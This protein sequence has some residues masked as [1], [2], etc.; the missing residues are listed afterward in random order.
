MVSTAATPTALL[1]VLADPTRLRILALL[2]REELAVGELCRSLDLA[3]SRVSNH[4]RVLREADFLIERHAGSSIYLRNALHRPGPDLTPGTEAGLPGGVDLATSLWATVRRDLGAIPEHAGDLQRLEAVLAERSA[5]GAAFFDRLAGEWDKIGVDFASGQARQRAAASLLPTDQVL[6]DLGCGT[7]YVAASLLGLCDRLICVDNSDAMLDQARTRLDPM[8][9][10]TRVEYR[11]GDM[12]AL[13]L[14]E[15]EVDGLVAGM[16][17]HHLPSLDGAVRE[18]RRVLK[19]GGRA[20]VLDLMPHNEAWM[21]AALGDRH[22]GLAP[23]DVLAA[24]ERAGF[25]EV[26]LEPADDRYRPLSPKGERAELSLYLVRA[27]APR[28]SIRT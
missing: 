19:P 21:H 27:T 17:L 1:K 25:A 12:D 20:V 16:V 2:E 18:M 15:A 13:P 4:L 10:T 5:D 14:A 22:L 11:S 23:R 24:F 28:D 26:R 8:P 3:Q 6:A 7:G 9:S